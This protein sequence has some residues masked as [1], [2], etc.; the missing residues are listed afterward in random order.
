LGRSVIKTP[1]KLNEGASIANWEG[2]T[3]AGIFDGLKRIGDGKISGLTSAC[4]DR[5]YDRR[6]F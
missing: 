3:L 4:V 1:N 5:K 6:S 2:F